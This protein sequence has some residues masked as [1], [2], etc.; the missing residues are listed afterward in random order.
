[1]F[2]LLLATALATSPVPHQESGVAAAID[3]V[4]QIHALIRSLAPNHY[5]NVDIGWH[6]AP[7]TRQYKD[8]I[9]V[10]YP[11]LGVDFWTG[12][13]WIYHWRV[14]QPVK[15]PTTF[16]KEAVE[17]LSDD[18][19]EEIA[20]RVTSIGLP[21]LYTVVSAGPEWLTSADSRQFTMQLEYNGMPY[22]SGWGHSAVIDRW[23][24]VPI[25]MA[26]LPG[27]LPP[28]DAASMEPK[29]VEGEAMAVAAV[30]YARH[31]PY[32]EA[33]VKRKGLVVVQPAML[34]GLPGLEARHTKNMN[35]DRL[36]AFYRIGVEGR[37]AHGMWGYQRIWIDA[38]TGRLIGI[39]ERRI[40]GSA[41]GQP[42]R[43]EWKPSLEPRLSL[44]DGA[45]ELRISLRPSQASFPEVGLR[46]SL[47]GDDGGIYLAEVAE[48][49][50][51]LR[52]RG[53]VFSLT[54]EE[55]ARVRTAFKRLVKG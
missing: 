10:T 53:M 24:G 43:P 20:R 42:Y 37:D 38:Q 23:S 48:K 22:E 13:L 46:G 17:P 40:D 19:C 51:L 33:Y 32:A 50:P 54:A 18:L 30:A 14:N 44:W 35:P 3:Q 2:T 36:M 11:G 5:Q 34:K 26:G 39:T 27:A 12:P 16:L 41:N 21:P 6:S 52:M 55:A 31:K 29:V 9:T 49:E 25:T 15:R 47:Y 4:N 28:G 1:M 8:T 7:Q 45:T